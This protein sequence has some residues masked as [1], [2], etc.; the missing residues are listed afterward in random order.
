MSPRT[1][2]PTD[3][4]KTH[5]VE[6]RM[7]TMDQMKLDYCCETLNLTKTEVVKK[8]IDMVYQQAY[9]LTKKQRFAAPTK[10]PRISTSRSFL[11]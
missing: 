9:K 7:S 10:A 4:P 5:R 6:I 2:R 11:L 1:G 3:E 8:G